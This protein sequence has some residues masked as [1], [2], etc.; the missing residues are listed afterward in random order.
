MRSVRE[1]YPRVEEVGGGGLSVISGPI[2]LS[3]TIL[4]IYRLGEGRRA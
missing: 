3:S 2:D 1:R 4:L